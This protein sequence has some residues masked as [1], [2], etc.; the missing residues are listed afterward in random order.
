MTVGG[1]STGNGNGTSRATVLWAAVAALAAVAAAVFAGL[2]WNE[3]RRANE[4][5]REA[6]DIAAA[7][8]SKADEANRLG[9]EGLGLAQRNE[10]RLD[11]EP[12]DGVQLGEAPT[13][14]KARFPLPDGVAVWFVVYNATNK[15]IENV[16][17]ADG[18]R[19][20]ITIDGIQPCRMYALQPGFEPTDLYFSDRNGLYWH[21]K[22]NGPPEALAASD[23]PSMP[24]QDTGGDSPWDLPL[25]NC[26][27]E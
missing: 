5:A 19:R 14:M 25:D 26:S 27:T 2:A 22:Y 3:T 8:N 9:E 21:R 17:V 11:R 4:S 13:E 12:V 15:P 7:A 20:S 1:S 10:E 24:A 16:W 18:E 6:N 23:F